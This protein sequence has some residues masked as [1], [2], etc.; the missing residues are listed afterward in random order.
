MVLRRRNARLQRQCAFGLYESAVSGIGSP[1]CFKVGLNRT[2]FSKKM[3]FYLHGTLVYFGCKKMAARCC[4]HASPNRTPDW[5]GVPGAHFSTDH[6]GS[7]MCPRLKPI[8]KFMNSSIRG[9]P[10]CVLEAHPQKVRFCKK[11]VI[12]PA[13]DACIFCRFFLLGA[14]GGMQKGL[15][16]TFSR[17][18]PA[19]LKR[20]LRQFFS[21]SSNLCLA[22]VI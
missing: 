16:V 12:L 4:R 15:R 18:R 2:Q 14:T 21:K 20:V 8:S 7:F 3:S 6:G 22:Q 19:G 17:W 5:Q 11:N 1:D 10:S 13:R 9:G